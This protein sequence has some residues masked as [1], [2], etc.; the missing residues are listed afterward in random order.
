MPGAN[1]LQVPVLIFPVLFAQLSFMTVLSN[2]QQ[3]RYCS[4]H[5]SGATTLT[6][7]E[8]RLRIIWEIHVESQSFQSSARQALAVHT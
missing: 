5:R 1:S 2:K 7:I 3:Q 4:R 8:Y 6:A